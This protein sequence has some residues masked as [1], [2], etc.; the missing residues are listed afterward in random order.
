MKELVGDNFISLLSVNRL[1]TSE[2][3]VMFSF[4]QMGLLLIFTVN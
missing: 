1:H 3:A 2:I 4:L